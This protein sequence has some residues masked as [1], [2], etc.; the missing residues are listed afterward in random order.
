MLY[1]VCYKILFYNVYFNM[2]NIFNKTL[3][4]MPACL[5]MEMNKF[6]S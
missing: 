1:S 6:V 4:C 3:I 5:W 2:F